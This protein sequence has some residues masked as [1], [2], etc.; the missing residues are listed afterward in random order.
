VTRNGGK[1][2]EDQSR[3]AQ[4]GG[5]KL[6][7]K[8]RRGGE[9]EKKRSRRKMAAIP[10]KPKPTINP[11][12]KIKSLGRAMMRLIR[13]NI[14]GGVSTKEGITTTKEKRGGKKKKKPYK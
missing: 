5:E 2:G 11:G 10:R 9:K 4:L 1:E 3:E 6:D 8:D 7:G 14:T 13:P 12:I